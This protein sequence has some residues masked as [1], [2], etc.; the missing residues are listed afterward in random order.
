[1][2]AAVRRTHECLGCMV[3]RS[4]AGAH[5]IAELERPAGLDRL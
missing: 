4:I 2:A 3:E 5:L 1:L